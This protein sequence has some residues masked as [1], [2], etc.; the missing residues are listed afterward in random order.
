MSSSAGLTDP[1]FIRRL[2]SLSLLARR[3]LG[4]KLQADRRT[5]R[6]GMGVQFADYAEYNIGDDHRA[7]DWRV[8][9]RLEQLIIKLFELEEDMTLVVLLDT[10]RSMASKLDHAK[11]LAAALAYIALQ[12]LDQVVVYGLSDKL[13]TIVEPCHGRAKLLPMLRAIDTAESSGVDSDFDA[14]CRTLQ[15]R[16]RR[17]AMVLPVSD[18]LFPT[19][20]ERGLGLLRYSNHEVFCLQVQDDADRRCD[21]RGDADLE[22][23]ETGQRRRVTITPTEAAAYERAVQDWNESL[24][25]ACVRAGTGLVSTTTDIA[26]DDIIQRILRRGGLVA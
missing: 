22:C 4:G 14:C 19:G 20:F 17:R 8:F 3:V 6:K 25:T 2:E 13:Q 9:G 1:A 7:I 24:R 21:L 10:S 12:G 11:R 18:F 26:F 23:V 16:H 15:A 5:N